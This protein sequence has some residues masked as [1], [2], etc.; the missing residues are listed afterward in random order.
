DRTAPVLGYA[1]SGSF[2]ETD[3]PD[4]LRAWLEGYADQIEQLSD[5][6]E[7]TLPRRVTGERTAA[8][9]PMITT[10]WSQRAPYNGQCPTFEGEAG[11]SATGCVATA[12]AQIMNYWQ[13]PT[14]P[15]PASTGYSYTKNNV[16]HIVGAIE[17]HTID[18]NALKDTY[19]NT[20]KD[21]NLAWLL[22]HCGQTARMKYTYTS[23]S[24]QNPKA[25]AALKTFGYNPNM[26]SLQRSDYGIGEWENIIY[27]ELADKRPVYYSGDSPTGGHAFICDGY[28][29]GGY[30]HI[31]WG[32]AG[33]SDGYFLLSLLSP[34]EQGT[35]GSAGGYASDQTAIVGIQI[36]TSEPIATLPLSC[37]GHSY[38][39]GYVKFNFMN[40]SGNEST[41]FDFGFGILLEDGTVSE[42]AT[43]KG[44]TLELTSIKMVGINKAAGYKGQTIKMVPIG[45]LSSDT[46]YVNLWQDG[47]YY[48][49]T[50]DSEGKI[51]AATLGG[52]PTLDVVATT[53]A[54]LHRTDAQV[55]FTLTNNDASAE[56]Q[57]P[58]LFYVVAKDP[59]GNLHTMREV[60]TTLYLRPGESYVINSDFVNDATNIWMGNG[61]GDYTFYLTT[62]ETDVTTEGVVLASTTVANP[63]YVISGKIEG[64]RIP[65]A[66][67]TVS[68]TIT[69]VGTSALEEK[70]Y[71]IIKV[72]PTG[73]ATVSTGETLSIAV[74]E[75]YTFTKTLATDE[76]IPGTYTFHFTNVK[77]MTSPLATET[78]ALVVP[79]FDVTTVIEGPPFAGCSQT[80]TY[81]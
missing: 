45:K 26:H 36:A 47:K 66:S 63:G 18:W 20:E 32:W 7:Y 5:D 61:I 42:H 58:V 44:K 6:K 34:K 8:I 30:F 64:D 24:T 11:Q 3:I 13:H 75:S 59:S 77:N 81:T 41:T 55:H 67:Q 16:E 39:G 71:Y 74:G 1:D 43:T 53:D 78:V 40:N 33:K 25:L 37:V 22:R 73:T 49:V 72:P 52:V 51:S 38:T 46:D 21:D 79:T 68:F 17:A 69:N 2:S 56:Y 10:R 65:G 70:T 62:S 14:D 48:S 12:M 29:G 54:D 23:S 50:T 76:S 4:A 19:S 31:N 80:V 15:L 9:E 27:D 35:G 57:Q 60:N 28:D